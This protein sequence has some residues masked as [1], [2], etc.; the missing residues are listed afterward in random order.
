[1]AILRDVFQHCGMEL[2]R[3]KDTDL[4]SLE[5]SYPFPNV[6]DCNLEMNNHRHGYKRVIKIEKISQ[7]LM[8]LLTHV[9]I[10]S[11]NDLSSHDWTCHKMTL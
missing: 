8:R 1:M 11:P 10:R 7:A 6:Y 4:H 5:C 9:L 3:C 2:K